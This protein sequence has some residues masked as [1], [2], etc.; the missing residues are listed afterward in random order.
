MACGKKGRLGLEPVYIFPVL[1]GSA[2]KAQ[3]TKFHPHLPS[4]RYIQ[5]DANTRF[6]SGLSFVVYTPVYYVA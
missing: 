3:L 5:D 2:K 1:V 4:I 6:F